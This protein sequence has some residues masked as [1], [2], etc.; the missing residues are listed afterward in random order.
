MISPFF[1]ALFHFFE[2]CFCISI[3]DSAKLD[4]TD[5]PLTVNEDF[6]WDATNLIGLENFSRSV[7]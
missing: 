4:F 3:T 6:S 7:K 1:F 2:S 5:F